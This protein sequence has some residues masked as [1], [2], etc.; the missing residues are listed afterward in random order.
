MNISEDQFR[1]AIREVA[2]EVTDQDVPPLALPAE[3]LRGQHV[4]RR[5]PANSRLL[6]SLAAA[7]AV[8][9]VITVSVVLS[10][11]GS[12]APRP[13]ASGAVRIRLG[14]DGVPPYYL[15]IGFARNVA[16]IRDTATGATI[17]TIRP[18]RPFHN[19]YAIT[20]AADYWTFA[21]AA[22]NGDAILSGGRLQYFLAQFNPLTARVT[23]QRLAIPSP[24]H[25][26][27]LT[28]LALSPDGREL[29]ITEQTFHP[30]LSAQLSVYSLA[31][32]Q[33]H[34]WRARGDYIFNADGGLS[35]SSSGTLAFNGQSGDVWLLNTATAGGDLQSSTHLAVPAKQPAGF[36][37]VLN[38]VVTLDGTKIIIP[39]GNSR[40]PQKY[41]LR[42]FSAATG[43]LLSVLFRYTSNA[44]D[45]LFGQ[46]AWTGAAGNVLV[47]SLPTGIFGV[48][49]A[50][51]FT[52][53][54]GTQGA[55][56]LSF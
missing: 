21:L 34:V 8:I 6:A 27:S 54:P 1:A 30:Q 10:S 2:D 41:E 31:T 36:V 42:V 53:I 33:V 44:N 18:P 50:D 12:D 35:W 48:L 37:Q 23:L 11:G 22:Y 52:P 14:L 26:F 20:G 9:G 56:Q 51:R 32:G 24:P 25:A 46:L 47:L 7:V 15:E 55:V 49:S 3:E 28:G 5:L 38:G 17:A 4:V 40:S 45:G 29:A 19:F 16:K 43:K 39:V 13:G